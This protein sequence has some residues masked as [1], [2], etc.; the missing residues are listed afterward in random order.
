M[1]STY[2]ADV[3]F[4][5]DD[6]TRTTRIRWYRVSPDTPQLDR[7]TVF[8]SSIWDDGKQYPA[9]GEIRAGHVWRNVVKGRLTLVKPPPGQCGSDDQWANG[10]LT[11]DPIPAELPASGQPSCCGLAQDVPCNGIALR[12]GPCAKINTLACPAGQCPL[13]G[14]RFGF[15]TL[16]LLPLSNVSGKLHSIGTGAWGFA[17]GGV[18]VSIFSNNVITGGYSIR[19]AGT[20][21][22]SIP[23]IPPFTFHCDPADVGWGPIDVYDVNPPF[24]PLG[25]VSFVEA[26][27]EYP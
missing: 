4:F 26:F 12:M 14:V 11:T 16:A 9:V 8:V 22:A 5:Q 20:G 6:P 7:P 15:G 27:E 2:S 18:T 25:L 10:C 23:N 19:I 3:H 24:H 1:R 17:I 13:V 21:F